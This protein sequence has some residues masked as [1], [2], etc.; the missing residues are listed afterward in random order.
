MTPF[1]AWNAPLQR[2]FTSF[3]SGSIGATLLLLRVV[4]GVSAIADAALTLAADHSASCFAMAIV[5]GLAGLALLPGFL[6]PLAGALLALEGA[7]LLLF[8][9]GDA[10]R[11]LH[12]RMALFEFVIMAATVAML[13]P[14]VT[15]IDARRFGRREVS[16]G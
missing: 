5:A 11:L 4:V 6:T 7:A 15:S 13:G 14:G 3:P 9:S 8:A 10:L 1:C 16:I 2:T 12:S